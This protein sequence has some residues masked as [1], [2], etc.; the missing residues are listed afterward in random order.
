MKT[1]P[2]TAQIHDLT[3]RLLL[4]GGWGEGRRADML[5]LACA[6]ISGADALVTWDKSDLA[7]DDA[8]RV[9]KAVADKR[10]LKLPRVGTPIE[11]RSWLGIA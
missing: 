6:M 3:E 2:A 7:N 1:V 8:R 9:F 4:A 11:V 10:R 5:H